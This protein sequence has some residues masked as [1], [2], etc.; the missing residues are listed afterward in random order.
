MLDSTWTE[1]YL[2]K[3]ETIRVVTRYIVLILHRHYL[4]K[5]GL[6]HANR[7]DFTPTYQTRNT[8]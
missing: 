5:E 3:T 8:W 4:L 7:N 6:K 1:Q 2:E